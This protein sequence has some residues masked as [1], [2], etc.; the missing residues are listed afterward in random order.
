[1][2]HLYSPGGQRGPYNWLPFSLDNGAFKGF[3]EARWFDL[4]KWTAASGYEPLWVAVPDKVGDS[5]ET[6]RLWD[7]Y[8]EF[9]WCFGWPLAFVAQDGHM[10]GDIP[11]EAEVI[12]IGGT[13]EWKR[14]MAGVFCKAFSRVHVG[15]VNTYRWLRYFCDLGAESCDGTGF[16]RGNKKQLAGLIQFFQEQEAKKV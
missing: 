1:V 10:P 7:K 5:R 3:D 6:L 13:T 11:T 2:G 9:A 14:C 12:F 16:G 15:R 4:L 8:V